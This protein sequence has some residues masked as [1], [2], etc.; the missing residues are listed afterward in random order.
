MGCEEEMRKLRITS[1]KDTTWQ[2]VSLQT[3]WEE[4]FPVPPPIGNTP[5]FSPSDR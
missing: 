4:A 5:S 1:K 2:N 3:W